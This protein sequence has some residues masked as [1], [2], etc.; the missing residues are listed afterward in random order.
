MKTR[1]LYTGIALLLASMPP[2][3]HALK[4]DRDQPMDILADRV[5]V[6]DNKGIS[7][8]RGKVRVTRGTMRI[9]GD[10]VVIYRDQNNEVKTIVST[11]N[12]AIYQQRPDNK[13]SDVVAR[14]MTIHYD[15][16]KEIIT[17][18]QQAEINQAKD[19]FTGEL[20]V[21]YARDD[22]VQASGSNGGKNR[23]RM[24]LQPS[25]KKK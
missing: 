20:L 4:S 15:A 23:V 19:I 6:D 9:L 24:T 25:N 10:V 16:K 14:G 18:K 21:Y 11:G 2:L 7:T 8:F 1:L 13:P 22:K 3:A 12:R 17:V 5:D